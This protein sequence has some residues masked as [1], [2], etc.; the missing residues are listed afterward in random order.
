MAITNNTAKTNTK[1]VYGIQV[2][3]SV[4]GID[5]D[6]TLNIN[7]STISNNNA[8]AP[9]SNYFGGRRNPI[10]GGPVEG[11]GGIRVIRGNAIITNTT[12]YQNQ[13][14]NE[15]SGILNSG[16]TVTLMN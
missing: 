7:D 16:G 11:G 3:G 2:D 15:G 8:A 1:S 10:I 14:G 5:S 6:G 12:V 4:G 13:S 9:Y